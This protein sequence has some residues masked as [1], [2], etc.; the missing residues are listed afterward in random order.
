METPL[1]RPVA[2]DL[3]LME[4]DIL[5]FIF[6]LKPLLSLEGDQYFLKKNLISASGKR[7]L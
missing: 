6:S 3:C 7:F 4:N 2:T 5:S 1:L